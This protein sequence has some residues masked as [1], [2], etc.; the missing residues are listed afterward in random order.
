MNRIFFSLKG[1][2][3]SCCFSASQGIDTMLDVQWI[4]SLLLGRADQ[5]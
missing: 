5:F 3:N 4:A 2:M 1:K